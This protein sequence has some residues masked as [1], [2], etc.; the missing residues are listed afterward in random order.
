V[1]A[2]AHLERPATELK[3]HLKRLHD[4]DP[5]DR[6][7]ALAYGRTLLATHQIDQAQTVFEALLTRSPDD[8][9]LY[10][11]LVEIYQQQFRIPEAIDVR[12]REEARFPDDRSVPR[13][14]GR[15]YEQVG[16]FDEAR[17]VYDSLRALGGDDVLTDALAS[18]RTYE[19][20][21][22]LLSAADAYE[23][24]RA[25]APDD[26]RVLHR[27]GGVQD[28]L[29]RWDEALAT[30]RSLAEH[31]P[32]EATRAHALTRQGVALEA[33]GRPDEALTTYEAAV[34]LAPD[35]PLAYHRY[36][37]LLSRR[38]GADA[39]YPHAER[40]LRK[41]LWAVED[42]Q[43]AVTRRVQR[44]SSPWQID[45]DA[46]AQR[47]R[48]ETLNDRVADIFTFYGTRFPQSQTK[49]VIQDLLARYPTSGRLLY[50][51]GRYYDAHDRPK[52]AL[53]HYRQ[54]VTHAPS[55][56][57]GHLALGAA[58]R[59]HDRPRAAIQSYE[60]ALALDETAPDAYRAL[61]DLYRE[62]GRLDAVIA[63]WQQRYRATPDN[64][65]LRA[66]LLEALHKAGR[67][68]DARELAAAPTNG[69]T[70]N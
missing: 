21:D 2:L 46:A 16:A 25:D 11:T 15:L 4:A 29:R 1:Q 55:L 20:Q 41:G 36:A 22:S 17:V 43:M 24:V 32:D 8:R 9:R 39:A 28:R 64:A 66:H 18:A 37:V 51:V 38:D 61:I 69:G 10:D 30:Y 54:A 63:R 7:V 44:A 68:A 34:V 23:A 14:I 58:Y 42:L 47:R 70:K 59:H 45:P 19:R 33:L 57:D 60:R 35:A 52:I 65:V 67:Y 50:L 31:A 53:R 40:A 27:L 26:V 56:R 48:I 49:P 13:S 12:R 6:E 5:T 62:A 3:P